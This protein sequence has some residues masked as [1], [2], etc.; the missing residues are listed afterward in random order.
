MLRRIT[1]ATLSL[2]FLIM[3]AASAQAVII[4]LEAYRFDPV[5]GEPELP[6]DLT[7]GT[8]DTADFGYFLVQ[9]DSPITGEWKQSL[10]SAGATLYGY[11]PDYAF[12]VGLDSQAHSRVRNLPEVRWMGHFHP[13]YKICPMIGLHELGPQR[14][15]DP[16]RTLLVQVFE[17]PHGVAEAIRLMGGQVPEV[18]DDGHVRRLLVQAPEE[19]IP[20]LAR[21]QQVWWIEERPEYRTWNHVTKWVV[22]SNTSGSTPLWDRGING[23]GQIATIMDSGVDYNSCWFRD[24]G[25]APPG[26]DH[27]KVIDYSLTGGN[28]YDGCSPGHGTHVAG[29]MAGDQSFINPGNY[30]HNGMAYKAKFTVQDVGEDDSWSCTTG[31]VNI[32]SSLYGAFVASYGLNARVHT[33]SWGSTSNSYDAMSRDVDRAMWEN[34]EFLIVFAAGNSGPGSGT[35]GT[36]G[37][38]KN[39]V[40]VGST[41]QAPQQDTMAG[42]S[43]RGPAADGRLKPTMTAPGGE[44]PTFIFSA[45]NHTGNPPSPTCNV[46]GSPFQGTSMA[47]PAVAGMALNVR[48]YF[49]DGYYPLG[50]SGGDPISPS[51]ALVKSVLISSTADMG[52]PNIPNNDEGW[53]RM[54]MD[55]SLYFSGD[56]RELMAEDVTPG[57]TTGQVWSD[58][59]EI[60]SSAEPLVITLVWTDYPGATGSGIKLVNNLDL[61]V[62]APG[63][64]QYKGNVFSGGFSVTGGSH[65]NLN[66][67]E[68][69]RVANPQMGVWTVEVIGQNVPQGPQ[70]FAVSMNGAFANWPE[71]DQSSVPESLAEVAGIRASPNPVSGMTRLYYQVPAGFSGPVQLD[72]VDVQGRLVRSLVSKGQKAGSYFVTWEGRDQAGARVAD[73]VYFARMQA[74]EHKT[75]TKVVI[76]R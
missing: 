25:N 41:R 2:L 63:G 31:A 3:T 52:T 60:D 67:E 73:G 7:F 10:E 70:P 11:I 42:Y 76:S 61:L 39:C 33:N 75:T 5:L 16:F 54:L 9:A 17:D 56:T 4:D 59:F 14:L 30:D 32:P 48:Q 65:D 35:V 71:D 40:T 55:N 38:A 28:P 43:S 47:T 34:K 13:A 53:G 58:E 49:E 27:R 57:L 69:V 72:I 50:E 46:Q 74:G 23:E 68:G 18:H 21:M 6:D 12:I 45:Q 51:A 1:L 19:L 62:T 20:E 66:V 24:V 8:R 44:S 15:A 22:Q 29:T 64:Q 36:P 37:T 26:P